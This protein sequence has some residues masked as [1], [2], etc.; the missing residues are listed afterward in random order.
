MAITITDGT[1]TSDLTGAIARFRAHATVD[2]HGAWIT[3]LRPGRLLDRN[4][5]I[6]ALTIAEEQARP[7]PDR[8]RIAALESA[9]PRV[10]GGR[11]PSCP[12]CEE[13]VPNIA[14]TGADGPDGPDYWHCRACSHEWA[15]L[16]LQDVP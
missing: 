6:T 12:W 14:W 7:E 2:G 15:T 3:S 16:A 10:R 11:T 4:Q 9:L 8:Q 5:A 1:M 13:T